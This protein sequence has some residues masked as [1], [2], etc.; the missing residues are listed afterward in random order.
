[1]DGWIQETNKVRS[2]IYSNKILKIE[3]INANLWSWDQARG[4]QLHGTWIIYF[5]IYRYIQLFKV[6]SEHSELLIK[7]L[8]NNCIN[9]HV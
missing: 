6:S 5:Y 9:N 3:E 8:K 1:M 2:P 7:K 4:I